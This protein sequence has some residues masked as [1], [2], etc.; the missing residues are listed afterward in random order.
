LIEENCSELL[1][2]GTGKDEGD[3]ISTEEEEGGGKEVI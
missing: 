3:G 2:M 1:T